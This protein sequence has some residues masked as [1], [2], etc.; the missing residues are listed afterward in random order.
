[1]GAWGMGVVVVAVEVEE[2]GGSVQCA[3]NK[4]MEQQLGRQVGNLRFQ[5][6]KQRGGEARGP[7]IA[8]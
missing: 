7:T 3:G 1:M 6:F 2:A 8:V 5:R 4:T